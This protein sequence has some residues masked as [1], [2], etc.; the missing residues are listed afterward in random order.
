MNLRCTVVRKVKRANG[1]GRWPAYIL[2]QDSFGLWL[3]SP[4]GTLYRGQTGGKLV[5][6]EVGQ[7]DRAGGLPTVQ[8]I[9][10][11]GWW[12]A[13]WTREA[14]N[15]GGINVDVCTPPKLVDGEWTYDDLELDPHRFP[16]GR[17]E[18]LD[19]DEFSVACGAGLITRT[20][21]AEALAAAAR[22]ESALRLEREPFGTTG[23]QRLED[24][25]ASSLPP[26]TRLTYAV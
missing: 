18:V 9:P 22:L 11:E 20:E 15:A 10:L 5:E 4:A 16:D 17:V 25:V 21:R 8:L 12:T 23:W 26:I 19:Q 3:Y 13:T 14:G 6:L 24:A 7:G 1:F 2:D